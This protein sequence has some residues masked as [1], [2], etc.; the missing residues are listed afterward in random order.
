MAPSCWAFFLKFCPKLSWAGECGGVMEDIMLGGENNM[1]KPAPGG[2][3]V[4]S[5]D[6]NRDMM[7]WAQNLG[8]YGQIIEK[9]WLRRLIWDNLEDCPN[10]YGH[11]YFVPS[12]TFS[13]Y[14][15]LYN[16]WSNTLAN[17]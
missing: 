9:I 16:F 8:Q 6:K 2:N 11:V 14:C 15:S 13:H 17:I 3:F 10:F 7:G 1:L 5:Y 12:R 4:P